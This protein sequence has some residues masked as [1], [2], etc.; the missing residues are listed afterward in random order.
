MSERKKQILINS[1]EDY[2]KRASPITSGGVH[3]EHQKSISPA[4]LRNELSALEAMGYLKQLHTSS[5]RV[6]TSKAYRYFVNEIM[7]ETKFNKKMLETVQ[8]IFI[9]RTNNLTELVNQIAGVISE[10]TNYPAVVVM[11]GYE[12]LVVENIKIV[13]LIDGSGILLIGTKSGYVSNTIELPNGTIEDNCVDASNFLTNHFHGV[14]IKSMIEDLPKYLKD[15]EADLKDYSNIFD[16]LIATLNKIVESPAV[17][18]SGTTKL[19]NNPEYANIDNAKQILNFL[20]DKN[21]VK[22][23]FDK[24]QDEDISFTIGAENKNEALE[25]CSVIQANYNIGDTTV[26][27]IG[28]IGPERMDY[29]RVASALKFIVQEL[30]GLEKLPNEQI[31]KLEQKEKN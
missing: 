5:G 28:V 20:D 13:P 21:E 30:K 8:K 1:V 27:S 9:K 17:A 14:T 16:G 3:D 6:P 10:A 23:L 7:K 31:K 29:S 4:T 2:I 18:K 15:M 24:N 11:K 26:A 22:D 12:G 25:N 19:L